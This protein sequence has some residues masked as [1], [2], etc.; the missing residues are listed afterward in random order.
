MVF[1]FEMIVKGQ[2]RFVYYLFYSL[3][4]GNKGIIS[5]ILKFHGRWIDPTWVLVCSDGLNAMA[6]CLGSSVSQ[7]QGPNW[8]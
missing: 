5:G 2:S 7:N 8:F 3:S 1:P 6:C 4:N